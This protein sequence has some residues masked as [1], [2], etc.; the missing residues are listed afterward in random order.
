[1]GAVLPA[2]WAAAALSI[3][4]SA[5]SATER[6]WWRTTPPTSAPSS[7]PGSGWADASGS[8]FQVTL[9]PGASF[10][11]GFENTEHVGMKKTVE[12]KMNQLTGGT[13][14]FTDSIRSLRSKAYVGVMSGGGTVNGVSTSGQGNNFTATPPNIHLHLTW[15]DNCP[16]W[17]YIRFENIHSGTRSYTLRVVLVDTTCGD[18]K[19]SSSAPGEGDD[20]FTI[21]DGSFGVPGFTIGDQ[22]ITELSIFPRHV[23]VD[24]GLTPTFVAGP[25]TGVWTSEPALIDPAG[26]PRPLG[27]VRFVT[28]GPGLTPEQMFSLSL[29]MDPIADTQYSMFAFD[30]DALEF[31]SYFIDLL[32]LPWWED[33]DQYEGEDPSLHGQGGWAGWDD[34]PAFDAPFT[35]AQARSAP[36]SL[37]A[38]GD[39]D[40]VRTFAGAD[41]GLWSFEAWQYIP[42]DF[43]VGGGGEFAGSYFVLLNTYPASDPFDW[44]VQVQFDGRDQMMKV[45]HGDGTNTIDVPYATDRWVKIE[46]IVDLESDWTQIYYDDSLVTEYTWTGGVLGGGGGVLDIA[47]VDLFAQGSTSVF[48]DDLSL[49]SIAPPCPADIDGDGDADVADFFAFVLAFATGDPAADINGDGSIDVGDF[50]AFVVAFVIGCP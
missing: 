17:E 29:G 25:E 33:F 48:Y 42:S 41:S 40:I 15:K 35:S 20:T 47:A 13:P 4:V 3:A 22:H 8:N 7:A 37:D 28:D 9:A 10:Y 31:Q 11:I 46:A 14:P 23:P 26:Q 27:G 2:L 12:F 45:F 44:S 30:A 18:A 5:A 21:D 38:S 39:T 19:K 34:D 49:I 36:N 32:E 1:M 6:A 24:P 16:D 43:A 50:F